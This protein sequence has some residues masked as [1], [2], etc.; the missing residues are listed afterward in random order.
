MNYKFKSKLKLINLNNFDNPNTKYLIAAS[1][2]LLEII[3]YKK[4]I[5]KIILNLHFNCFL[6]FLLLH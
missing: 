2:I 1:V 5:F 4:I 6:I 3:I